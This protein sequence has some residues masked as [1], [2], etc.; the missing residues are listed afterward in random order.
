METNR[1]IKFSAD[2]F[3]KRKNKILI[4]VAVRRKKEWLSLTT[5]QFK[6]DKNPEQFKNLVK[7]WRARMKSWFANWMIVK[8]WY[9]PSLD[10]IQRK[11]N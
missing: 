7:M 11:Y 4:D 3:L 1:V 10:K 9:D 8:N 6:S 5:S 2:D